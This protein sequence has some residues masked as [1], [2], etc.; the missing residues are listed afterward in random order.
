MLEWSLNFRMLVAH[1][2]SVQMVEGR[3][4]ISIQC[5]GM[6]DTSRVYSRDTA[7]IHPG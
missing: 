6:L 4:Y 2:L 3:V 5:F 1:V 7:R